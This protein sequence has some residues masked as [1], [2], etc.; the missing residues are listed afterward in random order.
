MKSIGAGQHTDGAALSVERVEI[1]ADLVGLDLNLT[2]I[3]R[4]STGGNSR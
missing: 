1:V 2:H 3:G 4:L